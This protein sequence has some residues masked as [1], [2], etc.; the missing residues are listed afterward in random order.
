MSHLEL[1]LAVLKRVAEQT[2][3]LAKIEAHPRTEGRQMLMVIAPK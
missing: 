3:E 1:G 2:E